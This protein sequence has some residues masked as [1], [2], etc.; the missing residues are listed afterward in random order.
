MWRDEPQRVRIP[1]PGHVM[2][3]S[4]HLEILLQ[5]INRAWVKNLSNKVRCKVGNKCS[6]R[7]LEHVIL[8]K[9]GPTMRFKM[10]VGDILAIC[11]YLLG[12]PRSVRQPR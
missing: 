10:S 3:F 1:P 11:D 12:Q 6:R 9:L 8:L 5:K 4:E 7:A 2:Y